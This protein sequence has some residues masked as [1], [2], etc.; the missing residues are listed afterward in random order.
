MHQK[1]QNLGADRKMNSN[2]ILSYDFQGEINSS[3]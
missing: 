3:S 2:I 1:F